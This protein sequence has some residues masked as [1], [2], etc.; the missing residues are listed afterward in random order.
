VIVIVTPFFQIQGVFMKNIFKL[1]G[2]IALVA[3][4]GF[5]IAACGDDD[6]DNTT[7]EEPNTGRLLI[8]DIPEKFNGKY[9][10]AILKTTDKTVTLY[11][12]KSW[13]AMKN[14]WNDVKISNGKATIP[15]WTSS[16]YL[17]SEY[18]G[19]DTFTDVTI[20]IE[21]DSAVI[22]I[23]KFNQI[24][25]NNGNAEASFNNNSSFSDNEGWY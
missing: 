22:A 15:V 21:N 3:V 12:H 10:T 8:T 9:A 23:I 25:F 2:I 19:N 11:G 16:G 6:K 18:Y 5:S 1:I 4:I 17:V 24:V 14:N 20:N 7:E 13:D